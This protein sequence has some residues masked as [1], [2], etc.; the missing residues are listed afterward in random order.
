MKRT[1]WTILRNALSKAVL[2]KSHEFR[3]TALDLVK[4]TPVLRGEWSPLTLY[5]DWR[6][7]EIKRLNLGFYQDHPALGDV[8]ESYYGKVDRIALVLSFLQGTLGL[9]GDVAEFGVHRG[10]TAI[11]LDRSLTE[12]GSEKKLHLFDSYAGMPEIEHPLDGAWKKGDLAFPVEEVRRLFQSSPRVNIVPG[13]FS[14]TFPT[15]PDLRF[16][17]CHVDADL[18]TSVKECIEYILPRLSVGGV[19]VFDDYGFRVTPGAKS[20]IEECLGRSNL[21]WV[22][23][24]TAQAV[25]FHREGSAALS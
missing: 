18:Y 22:P 20:A 19:I 8:F 10:H 23:L 2:F 25:Y 24:P 7:D 4:R 13:Y 1:V 5:L 16:S 6:H 14:D 3:V 12:A 11:A 21:T 15:A 17:F 9:P